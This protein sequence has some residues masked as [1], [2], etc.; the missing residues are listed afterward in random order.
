MSISLADLSSLIRV[1]AANL[2]GAFLHLIICDFDNYR[3][4]NF[5][6]GHIFACHMALEQGGHPFEFEVCKTLEGLSNF[7]ESPCVYVPSLKMIFAELSVARGHS[8]IVMSLLPVSQAQD[9]G[10]NQQTFPCGYR[11]STD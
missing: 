8:R 1:I 6:C 10:A 2:R 11:V 7:Q 3:R 4:S 5:H 9:V